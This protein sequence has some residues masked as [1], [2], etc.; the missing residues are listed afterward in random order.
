MKILAFDQ[1]TK[2]GW[3]LLEDGKL[4]DC[5]IIDMSNSSSKKQKDIIKE[6]LKRKLYL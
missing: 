1:A 2:T 5:G 6:S 4:I 3:C